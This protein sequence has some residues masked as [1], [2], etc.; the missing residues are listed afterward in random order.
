MDEF[1]PFAEL[2]ADY[3]QGESVEKTTRVNKV[4]KE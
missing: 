3:D 4:F 1:T 2:F